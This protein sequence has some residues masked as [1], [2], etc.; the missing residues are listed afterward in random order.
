MISS[1]GKEETIYFFLQVFRNR[2]PTIPRYILSDRDEGQLNAIE[3]VYSDSQ[4][5][6]CL[7]HVLHA[8]RAHLHIPQ[9]PEVWKMLQMLPRAETKEEADEIWGQIKWKAPADF[10][11]YLETNWMSSE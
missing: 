8:W 9:H 1:N 7:W 4:L 3:R 2:N 10:V 6:L 11:Q 5:F